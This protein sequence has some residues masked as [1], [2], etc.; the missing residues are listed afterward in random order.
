MIRIHK[1]PE[2]PGLKKYKSERDLKHSY[3]DGSDCFVEYKIC[4]DGETK[5]CYTSPY[6]NI[7]N[8]NK[9]KGET[10]FDE[11]RRQ[12]LKEQK[13]VCCYCGSP[14]PDLFNKHGKEQMKTEHFEPKKGE[15]ARPDLQ[16]N[17]GN[18]LAVC[19]GN[20]NGEGEKHC[21]SAKGDQALRHIQNPAS[22]NF[23]VVFEYR[24]LPNQQRVTVHPRK[25]ML[26]ALEIESEIT[27]L[28]LNEQKLAQKRFNLWKREIEDSI[29][30]KW[31]KAKIESLISE[32]SD[33]SMEK[34]KAYCDFILSYLRQ[35]LVKI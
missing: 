5:H 30:R 24:V 29:S 12:L 18:L 34:N 20:S 10:A 1:L 22:S 13:Y 3:E 28:N 27:L 17:Y 21:D 6:K 32:Y 14:I 26:N 35:K 9:K 16:L 7:V 8:E 15:N 2:P 4:T 19:L 23:V 11:L 25:G 31:T 33:K